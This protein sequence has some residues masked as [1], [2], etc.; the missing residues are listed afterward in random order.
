[1]WLTAIDTAKAMQ[2]LQ[3]TAYKTICFY[4]DKINR[5]DLEWEKLCDNTKKV[6]SIDPEFANELSEMLNN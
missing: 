6:K 2:H 1:M 3:E 4:N 5:L